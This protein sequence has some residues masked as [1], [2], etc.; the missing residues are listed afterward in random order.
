MLVNNMKG[1][2][3]SLS[4]KA[5]KP[6]FAKTMLMPRVLI[7]VVFP[8]IFEPVRS[9]M[10]LSFS[11]SK[12]LP[13][14]L[15]LGTK[16][17]LILLASMVSSSVQCISQESF[18]SVEK[19]ANETRACHSL[20]RSSHCWIWA[21]YCFYHLSSLK[22]TTKSTQNSKLKIRYI[23]LILFCTI[24]DCCSKAFSASEALYCPSTTGF[25]CFFKYPL[26]KVMSSS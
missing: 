15:D 13:T 22:R 4:A 19:A 16:G 3:L 11:K 1:P 7:K 25:W 10:R 18:S 20:K 14:Q 9:T 2:S 26:V 8:D 21:A 12:S 17:C 23:R 5:F 6:R 24:K